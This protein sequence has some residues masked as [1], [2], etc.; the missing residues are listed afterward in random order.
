MPPPPSSSHG[1]TTFPYCT[2]GECGI[3]NVVAFSGCHKMLHTTKQ[4]WWK[5]CVFAAGKSAIE[6]E[7]L[8]LG[9]AFIFS[10]KVSTKLGE[11]MFLRKLFASLRAIFNCVYVCVCVSSSPDSFLGMRFLR[12]SKEV[13]KSATKKIANRTTLE[14]AQEEIQRWLYFSFIWWDG[15]RI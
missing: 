8:Y 11:K 10:K 1:T 7:M 2:V 13:S 6:S 15:V 3:C 4:Q 9:Q 14:E 5:H 12:H